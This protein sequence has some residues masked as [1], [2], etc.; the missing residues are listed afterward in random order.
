MRKFSFVLLGF[1]T[2]LLSAQEIS[3]PVSKID[4]ALFENA[5]AIV[6]NEDVLIEV[7]AVDKMVIKRSRI[8]TVLNELGEDLI[9]AGEIYDDD[10]RIRKQ[11]AVI[12]DRFGKEIRSFKKKDFQ[13]RS[14]I[15]GGT[16]ISDARVS[17]I[18]YSP[19]VYP[20]TIKYISEVKTGST[21]FIN[22]WFPSSS[23]SLSIQR[24]SYKFKNPAKIPIRYSEKN[25]SSHN[26][27]KITS[28][29]ELEYVIQNLP[30]YKFEEFSPDI[31]YFAPIVKVALNQFSLIG[32]EGQAENWKQF[33]KWQYD[34]LLKD[35]LVIPEKTKLEVA[36]LT[37]NTSDAREKIRL[38]YNYVQEN[39]RYVS[40]QLG[41]GGWEPMPA[42]EVDQ[43]KYGD[44]KALTNYTRALLDSQDIPSNYTVVYG[45]SDLRDVDENFASMEGNHVI[46]QVPLEEDT[47]W[48][49]CTSQTTPF[50]YIAGFTDNRKVLVITP[51]G[52]EIVKTR[53]YST[54]DNLRKT[55]AVIT[56]YEQGGFEAEIQRESFGT[57]Y[58]MIYS[59]AEMDEQSKELFYKEEFGHLRNLQIEELV[60]FNDRSIPRFS[61]GLKFKGEK[62][63]NHLGN[64]LLLPL[65]FTS[66]PIFD[67]PRSSE[68]KLP[69]E[70]ERGLSVQDGFTF[71]LPRSARLESLPDKIEVQT[72]FGSFQVECR[73]EDMENNP[74]IIFERNYVLNTGVWA[75]E[76]YPAFREFVNNI[77]SLSNPKAVIDL[78]N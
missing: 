70:I 28:E 22:D 20:Y 73:Y 54:S 35:K 75:A 68:R 2:S 47:I 36:N 46:L 31:K 49:E 65:G 42:L 14:F 71:V 25:F 37:A 51:E 77:N 9:W 40:I 17:Y 7:L 15:T 39:T 72:E 67:V 26:I 23:Y 78:N 11:E 50:N 34:N 64:D 1:F 53:S 3:Y 19:K 4:D 57:P 76:K 55:T 44:C 41:I 69:F 13:D 74:V 60:H 16:L 29:F 24:S 8:I 45:G 6:R 30:A 27:N 33:G 59:I 61:E 43:L 52:G 10:T 32:V 21:I 63:A 66:L 12:F 5:N 56:V 18:D 48:L 58:G 62:Y 38:I